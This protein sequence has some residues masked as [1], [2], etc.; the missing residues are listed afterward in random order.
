MRRIHKLVSNGSRKI[1]SLIGEQ[2]TARKSSRRVM[3]ELFLEMAPLEE[4][5]LM[6]TTIMT[7]T[8]CLVGTPNMHRVC[9]RSDC[10]I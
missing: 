10:Q 1:Q 9:F 3:N 8:Y 5:V 7:I 4:R 6:A 2:K